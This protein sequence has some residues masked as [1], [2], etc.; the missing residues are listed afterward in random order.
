MVLQP[1]PCH[2]E[3]PGGRSPKYRIEL[4]GP[5][6]LGDGKGDNQNHAIIFTRGAIVQV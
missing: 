4:P 1:S 3:P 6:I 2:F 5:P